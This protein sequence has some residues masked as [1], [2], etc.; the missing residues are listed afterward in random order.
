MTSEGVTPRDELPPQNGAGS[1]AGP[2]SAAATARRVAEMEAHFEQQL[3]MVEHRAQ[4]A[5]ATA[6]L[7]AT[8][9]AEKDAQ[10]QLQTQSEEFRAEM[11]QLEALAER[12]VERSATV[13]QEAEMNAELVALCDARADTI[14]QLKT[15]LTDLSETRADDL[16]KH[17]QALAAKETEWSNMERDFIEKTMAVENAHRRQTKA[18]QRLAEAHAELDEM[19]ET[20]RKQTETDEYDKG[21]LDDRLRARLQARIVAVGKI[22]AQLL[23]DGQ[24]WASAH[25]SVAPPDMDGGYVDTADQRSQLSWLTQKSSGEVTSASQR[26]DG[27]SVET[28][29]HS[30]AHIP[31]LENE[32]D[33]ERKEAAEQISKL[34][35]QVRYVL[36]LLYQC[37]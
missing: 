12:A 25:F 3:E 17:A 37:V 36:A 13:E 1:E 19:H 16:R 32:L 34:H 22:H 24:L 21:L 23:V 5:I 30:L 29:A 33:L 28:P 4:M 15:E 26:R 8:A 11:A 7:E 27:S 18:E 35:K 10:K 31:D 9:Q 2:P 14:Q 20:L 6:R